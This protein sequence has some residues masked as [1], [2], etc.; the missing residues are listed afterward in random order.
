MAKRSPSLKPKT[1]KPAKPLPD[2][3]DAAAALKTF[4]DPKREVEALRKS[5]E[6]RHAAMSA[7]H[8]KLVELKGA[9]EDHIGI[10]EAALEGL[11]EAIDALAQA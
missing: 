3:P 1:L 5:L 10:T 6:K 11:S 9:V 4:G 7:E 8:A 2:V